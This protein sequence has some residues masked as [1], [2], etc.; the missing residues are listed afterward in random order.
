[1]PSPKIAFRDCVRFHSLT[2]SLAWMLYCFEKVAR[3]DERKYIISSVNDS[4]H[5]ENS[6]HYR[7]MAF[8][9][10][11]LDFHSNIEKEELAAKLMEEMN[12]EFPSKFYVLIENIGRA[13]EH[14]HIQVTK[15]QIFP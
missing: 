10:F 5:L 13:G 6:K 12:R 7:D 8:D 3:E 2:P 15:G 1:M 11:S 4:H 9:F 14:F